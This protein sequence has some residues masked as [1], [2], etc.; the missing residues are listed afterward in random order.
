MLPILSLQPPSTALFAL[1]C[2]SALGAG[3]ALASSGPRCEVSV[4]H[5]RAQAPDAPRQRAVAPSHLTLA[6][7]TPLPTRPHRSGEAPPRYA[8]SPFRSDR[9]IADIALD[10]EALQRARQQRAHKPRRGCDRVRLYEAASPE[11]R[12]QDVRITVTHVLRVE[13]P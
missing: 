11:S 5:Q 4:T 2:V 6:T 1:L 13:R 10:V 3:W 12:R 9:P 7:S 8:H